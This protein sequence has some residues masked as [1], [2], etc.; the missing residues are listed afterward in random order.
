MNRDSLTANEGARPFSASYTVRND[1][2]TAT[3]S[4]LAMINTKTKGR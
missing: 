3:D 2:A 4:G 1:A